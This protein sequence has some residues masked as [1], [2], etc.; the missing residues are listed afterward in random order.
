MPK[1]KQ[2]ESHDRFLIRCEV[3]Q[4]ALGPT[5]ALLTRIGLT[6]IHFELITD[7]LTYKQRITH[8]VS[9]EDFAAE[10]IKDH[11]TFRAKDL[12]KHFAASGRKANAA[13]YALKKLAEAKAVKQLAPG[14]YQRAD[15][16]ALAPPKTKGFE[17][18]GQE[19]VLRF[20]R[21][22]HGR[23]NTQQ[24]KELFEAEGRNVNSVFPTCDHL[25]KGKL[26]KRVGAGEYVLLGK[27]GK[28]KPR[29]AAPKKKAAIRLN[30]GAT[31]VETVING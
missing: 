11:A 31:P 16:K 14:N 30:G 9:A 7:V 22:H 15:V 20:A 18:T 3:D 13:Y 21:K 6:N 8:G 28:P 2:P 17:Y 24:L 1:T 19:T 25:L 29:K 4:T 12:A 5:V 26:I 27:G 23:F 10:W